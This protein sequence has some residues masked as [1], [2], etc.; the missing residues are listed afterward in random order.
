MLL[1]SERKK[2]IKSTLA[3]GFGDKIK[4]QLKMLGKDLKVLVTKAFNLETL[5]PFVFCHQ[6]SYGSNTTTA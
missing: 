4:R 1:S 6:H 5:S 3:T 2:D